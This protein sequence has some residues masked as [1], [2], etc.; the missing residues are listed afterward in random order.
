MSK[1]LELKEKRAKAWDA[2]KT[3][4]DEH[5]DANGLMSAEDAA[6]Y[7]KMEKEIMDYGAA[8]ARQ[9]RREEWDFKMSQPTSNPIH[10]DPSNKTARASD[11]YKQAFW[12][13]LRGVHNAATGLNIGTN[14]E[15]GY[16]VPDEFERTLV[17]ALEDNN[18]MRSISTTIRTNSGD[19]NIPVVSSH[20]SADWMD[21]KGLYPEADDAFAQKVIGAYKLGTA[22]RISE[23]LMNDSAFNMESYIADVFGRRLGAKEEEAFLVGDG[24]KKPT[25]VFNIAE[26]GAEASS[27]KI[28]FDDVM[29]L[30]YSLRAPYRQRA[31]FIL[32]DA[33]VK[34]LRKLKDSNGNY[35]WQPSTQVGQPDLILGRPYHTSTYAPAIEAGAKAIAFGDFKY[36]WIADR[37][38]RAFKRLNELYAANGQIGFLASQRVDGQLILPEAVKVLSIASSAT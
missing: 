21:E 14:S 9:E 29:D 35:I 20:G 18:F 12:N 11:E 24:N 16:L 25:G 6:T 23:E 22:I 36:Y 10:N 4:L 27:L 30:Y 26:S 31:S 37:E 15:G 8:I 17:Q 38:G 3:F 19:R 34:A 7:D 13:V 33:S 5:S 28:T 32:N 1:I 2:A